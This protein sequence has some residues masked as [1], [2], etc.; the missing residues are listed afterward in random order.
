MSVQHLIETK[1]TAAFQPQ[2]LVVENES[3]Q[4]SVPENAETHFK[5]TLVSQ[6]FTGQ[7]RVGR[8]QAVYA[9]LRDELAGAVHALA[10]HTYTPEEWVEREGSTP[11]SPGCLGGSK[12]G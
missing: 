4:H 1:L 5:V 6:A 7:R 8:H 2:W 12:S 3:Y 10:L 11:A 9:A